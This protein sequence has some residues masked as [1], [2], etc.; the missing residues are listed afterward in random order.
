MALA[1]YRRYRPRTFAEVIGQ[2]HVTEP[3]I[4]A[5][6]SGRLNH[7]YLFSGPRGCGK[8]TSARILARSLNCAKGPTPEPC[9]ECES[10]KALALDGPGSIDVIEIDAASHGGVDDARELRERAFFAPAISRYKIYIIDEAHM[11]S[12]AGFNA[13]LKLVEE[14]PD[15]VKFIFA[16]TEPEKVLGT[17]RSRT[18]HY[19]FRLIPPSALRPYLELLCKLEEVVVEPLVL[20]LVVRA[21]GGS[22]RDSLSVLDQ[23]IAGSG[24]GGVTYARAVALLGV[25]DNALIDE[26]VDALA[27]GDGAAAFGAIDRVAEAGHDSRRYAN[28]LL[29][30]LRDLIILRQVPDAAGKGLVDVPEEQLARMQAQAAQLGPATLSRCADIVANGLVEMRGATSPRLLLELIAARMMLPAADESGT[31]LL[32]R[33]E[34][35]ETGFVPGAAAEAP[36]RPQAE[37][38]HAQRD[39]GPAQ[40]AAHDAPSAAPAATGREA[41]RA[42][43]ASAAAHDK[44]GSGREAARAAAAENTGPAQPDDGP[45]PQAADPW[46]SAEPARTPETARAAQP[47]RAAE[48]TRMPAPATAS[49]PAAATEDAAAVRRSW[50]E[51]VRL[52]GRSSKKAA[53]FAREA[54]VRDIDGN[55]LV[56]LFKHKIH[57]NG[58][59]NDPAPLMEAVHQVLG[60]KWQL[61][62]EVGGD[63]RAASR[64]AA[65][66]PAS[67]PPRS[68]APKAAP[69]TRAPAPTGD[70][71][72]TPA[73]VGGA[74]PAAAPT[75]ATGRRAPAVDDG[76]P[77]EE[78]PYDP[79]YDGPPPRTIEGFDPGDEPTDEIVDAAVARQT[80]EQAA[81]E[82]LRRSFNLEK[83]D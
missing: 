51:I 24:P 8:T 32:Q 34:R 15:Y 12:S 49:A 83:L 31:A 4:Q 64:A 72:P 53:A 77:L 78:P 17:I 7:A 50:D 2:D 26:M 9:G 47:A 60:G 81:V 33:L 44:A 29:E 82:S 35:L 39:T 74:A 68:T 41:A 5:L 18:H 42:A 40:R 28:D 55:T 14:P 59:E 71:W 54:V 75:Q 48:P 3:L 46:T 6:K 30:R 69:A 45:A 62:C 23:L 43:A 1:L 66:A 16:T 36:V 65:A 76:P 70:D 67:A 56:L 20:P 37:A 52:V 80:T 27:A 58:V 63:P 19:P 61:R 25:T 10:C 73:R 11:V 57:A 21:G 38:G 13:L 79:E 22:A